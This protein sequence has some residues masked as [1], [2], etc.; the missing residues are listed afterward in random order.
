[1]VSVIYR[2]ILIAVACAS[3]LLGIQIPNFINQYEQRLDAHFME[4]KNNLRGYQEI[5]DRN[6]GGSM[7]ALI[8]KHEQSPDTV[9]EQEAEPIRNIYRRYLRFLDE[10]SHLK[11]SFPGKALFVLVR[12]DRELFKETRAN[13]SFSVPFNRPAVLTGSLCAAVALFLVELLRLA[14]LRLLRRTRS[15]IGRAVLRP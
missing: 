2:Y 3:L 12:G 6:F 10:K 4:V 13:Y 14:L 8:G 5:A 15:S 9:F 7:E 11:T 1:M